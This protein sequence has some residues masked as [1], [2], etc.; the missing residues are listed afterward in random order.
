[1]AISIENARFEPIKGAL[2][3]VLDALEGLDEEAQRRVLETV[4]VFYGLKPTIVF[5][6]PLLN[7]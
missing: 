5:N 6:N 1:M 7:T 3:A 4:A 2:V